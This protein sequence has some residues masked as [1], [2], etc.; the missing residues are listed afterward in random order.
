MEPI[1]TKFD[2]LIGRI[3]DLSL[4]VRNYS[5]GN[6]KKERH[7]YEN[8]WYACNA[9]GPKETWWDFIQNRSKRF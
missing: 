9:P 4:M 3:A 7:N 2:A 6:I 5:V 8:T 1:E